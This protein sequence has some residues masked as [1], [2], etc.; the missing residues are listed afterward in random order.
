MKDIKKALASL[1][2]AKWIVALIPYGDPDEISRVIEGLEQVYRE[3]EPHILTLDEVQECKHR[4]IYLITS[5][6]EYECWCLSTQFSKIASIFPSNSLVVRDEDGLLTSFPT[7][8]YGMEWVCWSDEPTEEQL[9]G[10]W[11]E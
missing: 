9:E 11:G 3:I 8:T 5:D 6:G 7:E 2:R 1:E 4:P 10:L